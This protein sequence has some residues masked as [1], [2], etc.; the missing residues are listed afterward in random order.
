MLDPA[1]SL[2][3]LRLSTQLAL[4]ASD[5]REVGSAR[6]TFNARVASTAPRSWFVTLGGNFLAA[7]TDIHAPNKERQA[8]VDQLRH[9]T[10]QLPDSTELRQQLTEALQNLHTW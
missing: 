5:D 10:K 4:A 3:M 7:T 9:L 8:A 6:D 2:G 1:V